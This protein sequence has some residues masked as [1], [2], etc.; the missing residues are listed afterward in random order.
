MFSHQKTFLP[1]SPIGL[2]QFPGLSSP[3]KSQQASLYWLPV[4]IMCGSTCDSSLELVRMLAFLRCQGVTRSTVFELVGSWSSALGE[5]HSIP[6]M[7]R[8]SGAA[9]PCW[10]FFLSSQSNSGFEWTLKLS[11]FQQLRIRWQV[12]IGLFAT[13][14]PHSCLPY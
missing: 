3:E 5:L 1:R 4:S 7:S 2:C 8:S 11:V 9:T 14:L 10:E 13:S 6:L 12:S